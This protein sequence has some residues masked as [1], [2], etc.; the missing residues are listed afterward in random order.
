MHIKSST[1]SFSDNV[2][3]Q[4]D[5]EDVSIDDV[6]TKEDAE[7]AKS[8]CN[9]VKAGSNQGDTSEHNSEENEIEFDEVDDGF[10]SQEVDLDPGIEGLESLHLQLPPP[11]VSRH[12]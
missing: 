6:D 3:Q 5:N 12:H 11:H 9:S 4:I 7:Y 8:I 2:M 1:A 10:K